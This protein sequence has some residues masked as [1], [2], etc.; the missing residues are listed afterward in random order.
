MSARQAVHTGQ[1]HQ[2]G[3]CVCV[4]TWSAS[5]TQMISVPGMGVPSGYSWLQQLFRL[6]DLPFISPLGLRSSQR[7]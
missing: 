6:P 5:K 7:T 3:P 2:H 1:Q 4:S